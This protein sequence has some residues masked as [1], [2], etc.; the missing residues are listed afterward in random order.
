MDQNNQYVPSQS[1]MPTSAPISNQSTPSIDNFQPP[2]KNKKFGPII[3]I[4]IAVLVVAAIIIY[5]ISARFNVVNSVDT[6]D[7]E[8]NVQAIVDQ[9]IV[10]SPQTDQAIEIAPITNTNDDLQSLQADLDAS[11]SGLDDQSI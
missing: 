3:A 1:T 5:F 7:S 9:N 8:A 11:I 6:T 4:F 10:A 2:I